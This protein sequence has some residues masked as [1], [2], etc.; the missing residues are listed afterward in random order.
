MIIDLASVHGN[1]KKIEAAFAAHEIELDEGVSLVDQ[2][3]LT[4]EIWR[5][6]KRTELNGLIRADV[7][8]ECTRCLEPVAKHFDIRFRA[9]FVEPA[10]A[11][12][13]EVEIAADALD[14]SIVEDGRI[15]LADVV[16]EQVLLAVPEQIFCRQECHGICVKCGSN[17]NLIDCKCADDE[18]DPRWAT[19]KN[20]K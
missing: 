11:M 5:E 16:R 15:D 12:R 3:A 7:S 8:L 10:G 6:G 14:E 18:I 9:V 4:G 1:P 19:L 2:T 17:L 13:T 20:L